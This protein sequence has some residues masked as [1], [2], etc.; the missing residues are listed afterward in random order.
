MQY[1][2]A[3]IKKLYTRKLHNPLGVI[4]RDSEQILMPVYVI[5]PCGMMVIIY[6]V[7]Q[8]RN[9]YSMIDITWASV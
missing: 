9:N 1:A 3:Y 7:G 2:R 8:S 5:S 6:E 4:T